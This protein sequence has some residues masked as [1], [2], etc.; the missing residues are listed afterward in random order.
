MQGHLGSSCS[1][2]PR[3]AL[4][5]GL[6]DSIRVEPRFTRDIDLAV[7]VADD[8]AAEAVVA[9]FTARGFTLLVSLEQHLTASAFR[10]S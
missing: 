3:W 5:G 7:S 9:D 2:E 8:E 1:T 6:A 4:V 10:G